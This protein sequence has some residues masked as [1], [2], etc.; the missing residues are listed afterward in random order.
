M[1]DKTPY[2]SEKGQINLIDRIQSLLKYGPSW[3]QQL[4]AQKV[5]IS[6]LE[7]QL[8]NKYMLMRNVTLPNS[9]IMIPIIL[10]GPQGVYVLNVTHLRGVYQA[11]NDE[12]GTMEGEKFKPASI[13]LLVRTARLGRA[14]EVYLKRQGHETKPIEAV[15]VGAD[16]G[17]HVNS[18]RPIVRVV[19]SDAINRFAASI[20]A[21]RPVLSTAAIL[22]LAERIQS[23]RQKT[24]EQPAQPAPAAKPPAFAPQA[25]AEQGIPA[26]EPESQGFGEQ[27]RQAFESFEP[28]AG[29]DSNMPFFDAA[30]EIAPAPQKKKRNFLGMSA[31]QT[32]ALGC[33]GVFWLFIIAGFIAYLV[34]TNQIPLP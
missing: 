1:I 7:K 16:P 10:I 33:T 5:V 25:P 8:D 15:L 30:P 13:N 11:K 27:D 18:V 29:Y 14:L 28:D 12:W 9:E 6:N 23:P 31:K 2:L 32:I 22:D 17:L 24:E 20:T 3:F 34:I 19:L 4:D 21:A 26:F